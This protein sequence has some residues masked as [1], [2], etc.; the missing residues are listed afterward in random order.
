MPLVDS[1]ENRTYPFRI[2]QADRLFPRLIGLLGT[3]QLDSN[4]GLHFVP[5]SSIHTF[6]MKYS[7][8]VLFL[9]KQGY[10]VHLIQELRPNKM[11]KIVSSARSVLELPAG[12]IS[13]HEIEVGIKLSIEPDKTHCPDLDALKNLFHWPINVFIAFLWSQFVL[14]AISDWLVHSEPLNLGVIIHN[15]LLLI[16]FLTRR[17]SMDTSY[18]VLDWIVPIF[19]LT[20]VMM[21]RGKQ[22]PIQILNVLS[23]S[24]QILGILGIII[25]LFSLGRSFGVIPANRSIQTAGAYKLVRHPLY[26]C[27]MVFYLGFLLGNFSPRNVILVIVIIAGQVWRSLSEEKL[28]SKDMTYCHFLNLVRYRFIPGVF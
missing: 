19:V 12:S 4:D 26:T 5:C 13:E 1:N 8:D 6:G 20:C 10:V 21:L 2:I 28:L 25:S 22:T 9:D 17:K 7:V 23:N 11:T 18:R 27:E 14:L 24:L 16:L 3:D 15:T